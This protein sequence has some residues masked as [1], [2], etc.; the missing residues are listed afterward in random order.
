MT[1][2]QV[3]EGHILKNKLDKAS[4]EEY[5]AGHYGKVKTET[6]FFINSQFLFQFV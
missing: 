4:T 3:H 2:D 1:S 6:D 5:S